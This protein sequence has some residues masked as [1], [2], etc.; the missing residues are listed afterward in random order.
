MQEKQ[1]VEDELKLSYVPPDQ[2]AYVWGSQIDQIEK[3]MTK[4]QADWD[5]SFKLLKRIYDEE[6]QLWA[7]HRGDEVLAVVVSAVKSNDQ[8][9][10]MFIELMAGNG[11][12]D[13]LPLQR[14]LQDFARHVGAECIEASCRPGVARALKEYGW[15]QKAIIMELKDGIN[16]G[17]K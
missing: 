16:F 1:K 6:S 10:K 2:V 5:T 11:M 17:R 7:V 3:A 13:W 9:T 14:V 12:A 15:S 4:G 8:M